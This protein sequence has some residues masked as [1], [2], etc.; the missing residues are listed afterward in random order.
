[1]SVVKIKIVKPF[2]RNQSLEDSAADVCRDIVENKMFRACFIGSCVITN[3]VD[4][5]SKERLCSTYGAVIEEMTEF[6]L[7]Y[8]NTNAQVRF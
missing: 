7:V 1:M 6:D 4:R 2:M 3:Y 8:Y 5:V